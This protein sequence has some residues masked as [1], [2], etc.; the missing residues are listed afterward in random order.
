MRP[1]QQ[2]VVLKASNHDARRDSNVRRKV[3]DGRLLKGT[4]L[5]ESGVAVARDQ[6]V[7]SEGVSFPFA[8]ISNHVLEAD[9]SRS[10][11]VIKNVPD[12]VE[13]REPEHVFV[14]VSK[15]Q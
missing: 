9:K 11:S 10:L 15:A 8:G 1:R 3:A 7:S 4:I 12:L 13:E 6:G 14:R 5:D 2:S